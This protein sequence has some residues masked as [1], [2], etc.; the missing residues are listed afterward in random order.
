VTLSTGNRFLTLA[1]QRISYLAVAPD[2]LCSMAAGPKEP[3]QAMT[4]DYVLRRMGSKE[5]SGFTVEAPTR[6]EADDLLVLRMLAA[7]WSHG[8]LLAW[9][10]V[11][12]R[13][14][15]KRQ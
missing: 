5:Q 14:I 8:G 7:G 4:F 9:K 13:E 3:A 2:L 11:S 15:G 12:V 10:I 1:A 6:R